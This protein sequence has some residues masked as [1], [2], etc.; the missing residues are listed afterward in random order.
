MTAL[1]RHEQTQTKLRRLLAAREFAAAE[2]LIQESL[3]NDPIWPEAWIELVKLQACTGRGAEAMATLRSA[4]YRIHDCPQLWCLLG[5]LKSN[6]HQRSE[7]RLAFEKAL[8][9]DPVS[10]LALRHLPSLLSSET[11]DVSREKLFSWMLVVHPLSSRAFLELAK[12]ALARHARHGVVE[13]RI[14]GALIL[15]PDSAEPYYI[16]GVLLYRELNNL[17]AVKA[18]QRAL[19]LAPGNPASLFQLARSAFLI[20]DTETALPAA[21]AAL[22][23]GYSEID[24]RFLLARVFRSADRFDESIA[25]LRRVEKID[26]SY[27]LFARMVEWTVTQDDFQR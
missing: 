16:H 11:N 17:A 27:V 1:I 14:K 24:A 2:I 13:G 26:P 21:E 15:A 19:A 3:V 18:F 5:V 23:L 8:V 6:E 9:T 4:L 25:E 10:L 12:L 22:E 20:G 7:A